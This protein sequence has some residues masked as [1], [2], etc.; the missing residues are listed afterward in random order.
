MVADIRRYRKVS[1]PL[2]RGLYFNVS[3]DGGRVRNRVTEFAQRLQ[4]PFDRF[5]D[6]TLRLFQSASSRDAPGQIGNICRPVALTLFKNDC[7]PDT[8]YF[9]SNP[10]AF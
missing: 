2:R 3:G 10:A 7:V 5:A 4:M 1:S 6:V 9:L 8:H